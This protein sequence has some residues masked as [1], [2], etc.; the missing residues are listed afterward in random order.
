MIFAMMCEL[1]LRSWGNG[2]VGGGVDLRPA[3]ACSP[4]R[5]SPCELR[6]P[7][8]TLANQ[9]GQSLVELGIVV[10]VLV[11][12]LVGV[13]QYGYA[14]LEVSMITY[15]AGDGARAAAAVPL[16][17]R[18]ANGMINDW[19][20]IYSL[21]DTEIQSVTGNP[22]PVTTNGTQSTDQGVPLVNITVSG[23]VDYLF[24]GSFDVNHVVSFRDAGR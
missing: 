17:G 3:A 19:S 6:G 10:V 1:N 2:A 12:L 7:T 21:V 15:A 24:G 8:G 18:D 14:F 20:G 9:R 4:M 5:P 13:V 22:S 16:S 11:L 23:T